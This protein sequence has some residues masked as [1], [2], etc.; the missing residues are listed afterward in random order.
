MSHLVKPPLGTLPI[1]G[2]PLAQGLVGCWLMNEGGGNMIY[3]LSGNGN[4]G[5]L[6]GNTH[7]VPGKY[8]SCL[9]FPG[10]GDYVNVPKDTTL[11]IDTV[12]TISFWVFFDGANGCYILNN[13]QDG[14][15]R[16]ILIHSDTD[17][18]DQSIEVHIDDGSD[19][20]GGQAVDG[21]SRNEWHHIVVT[22]NRGVEDCK[23]YL[24]GVA[25]TTFTDNTAGTVVSD[26]DWTFGAQSSATSKQELNGKIDNVMIFDRALSASEIQ[27]L[28]CDPFCMFNRRFIELWTGATSSGI[29]PTE[30]NAIFFGC[31]F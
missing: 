5:T 26:L 8:G 31:N 25:T 13:Y 11:D 4:D 18:S 24:D 27:Q 10:D 12:F 1:I 15:G 3:D 20:T 14:S 2:H 17:G 6:K 7:W 23:S 29:T 19:V 28:Y 30:Q 22:R 9:D 16:S 21:V